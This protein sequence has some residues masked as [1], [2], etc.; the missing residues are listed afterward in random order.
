MRENGRIAAIRDDTI[1]V[2][3][4]PK[5]SARCAA[6]RCCGD[7]ASGGGHRLTLRRGDHAR[8]ADAAEGDLVTLDLALP[9]AGLAAFLLFGLPLLTLLAGAVIAAWLAPERESTVVLGGGAGLV[10]GGLCVWAAGRS[11]ETRPGGVTVVEVEKA[12]TAA[13]ENPSSMV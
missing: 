7:A 9:N 4:M 2:E 12:S 11:I 6:C 8:L 1:I 3:M 5:A 13:K 10:F